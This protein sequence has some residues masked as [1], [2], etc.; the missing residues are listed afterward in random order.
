[1]CNG[2]TASWKGRWLRPVPF[3]VLSGDIHERIS[4]IKRD[5]NIQNKLDRFNFAACLNVY[6]LVEVCSV[7]K[8]YINF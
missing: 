8:F 6:V 2:L 1:M 5:E 7:S 4:K 3:E